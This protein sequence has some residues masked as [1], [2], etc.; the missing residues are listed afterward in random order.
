MNASA[1]ST[2]PAAARSCAASAA[3][4]RDRLL[5][6]HVLAGGGGREG[7]WHVQVIGQRVVDRLDLGIGQQCLVRAI[8]LQDAQSIRGAARRVLAARG[9]RA[10][11]DQRA[12]HHSWQ[13]PVPADLRGAEHTP[14]HLPHRT[15]ASF[16]CAVPSIPQPTPPVAHERFQRDRARRRAENRH[17]SR[18]APPRRSF[19]LDLD[20][21][22]RRKCLS[23][24]PKGR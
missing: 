4:Y 14:Y 20:L 7:Q 5:A 9:D 17:F 2:L 16:H 15:L 24:Q 18:P 10:N 23:P 12:L 1:I 3:R 19:S 11:V 22:D 21:R 8:R 6:Q 13:H